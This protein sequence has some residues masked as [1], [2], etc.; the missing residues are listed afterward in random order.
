MNTNKAQEKQPMKEIITPS[1]KEVVV[2]AEQV[3]G[4]IQTVT[5]E[6]L[7]A[8]R[9]LADKLG[10]KLSCFLI[11]S[12][13]SN[14][15]QELI[16]RGADVVYVADNPAL[17]DYRVLPY[18]KV[19]VDWINN[20]CPP[21]H[22][23]LMGSTTTGRDLA[24]RIASYFQ[25]GL[26]ADCTELDIGP[27]EHT[28]KM[29]PDK[30]GLYPGC[31]YAIRPSFGESL[32][33][34]ILGPWKNPQMATARPGVMIP[35]DIDSSRKGEIINVPVNL[36]ENELKVDI[37]EIVREINETV[38]LADANVIVS[39]GFGLGN[40]EGFELMNE[41]ANC[42]EGSALGASRKVVD[43]GWISYQHQV[44]QT[45]K[46]VRPKIYI[47]C[48][49]SGAIQHRVGMDKSSLIIAINKDPDAPIF[50]FA[51]HGIVGDVYHIV[52]EMI[53]QLKVHTK[54][55]TNIKES[56]NTEKEYASV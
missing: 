49:I 55:T 44:G 52:P 5:V 2:I 12:E 25:T 43:L 45:G 40:A 35:L 41:L 42:F 56:S 30:I 36:T 46:T 23:M 31:L 47:A 51:H 38:K 24:P 19:I 8:G 22:I 4:E 13:F 32:K 39:G 33:A 53:K 21:P 29:D 18:K 54:S 17:K 37:L 7:G 10:G 1:N 28:N 34:R 50:K 48:G 16:A 6:L 27:Y 26:T 14:Q 20:F 15:P 3:N 9:R 11:G